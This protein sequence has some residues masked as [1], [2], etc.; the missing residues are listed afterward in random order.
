MKARRDCPLHDVLIAVRIQ[1]KPHGELGPHA[2]RRGDAPHLTRR[3]AK[4]YQIEDQVKGLDDSEFRLVQW[5][6]S[7]RAAVPKR[8]LACRRAALSGQFMV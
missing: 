8:S 3:L 1:G 6:D 7:R 5:P 2:I 4:F